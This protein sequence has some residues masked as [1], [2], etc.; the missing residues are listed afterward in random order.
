LPEKYFPEF[1]G[2]NAPLP[3]VSC[4]YGRTTR[5]GNTAFCLATR[6]KKF[7][8]LVVDVYSK[9]VAVDDDDDDDDD[10]YK[11]MVYAGGL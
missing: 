11:T 4:A 6:G 9:S 10:V 2:V 1:C 5:C 7:I 3:S 8:V